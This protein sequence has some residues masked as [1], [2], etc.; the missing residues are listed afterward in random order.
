MGSRGR[1]SRFLKLV[2]DG[3]ELSDSGPGYFVPEKASMISTEKKVK[4]KPE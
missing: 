3:R 2:V 1:A 4:P